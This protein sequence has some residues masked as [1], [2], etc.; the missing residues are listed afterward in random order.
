MIREITHNGK[1]ATLYKSQDAVD[2]SEKTRNI[3]L[4]LDDYKIIAETVKEECRDIFSIERHIAR[5]N[6]IY[7]QIIK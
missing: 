3:L 7:R 6:E 1:Y 5:L 2:F 4:E